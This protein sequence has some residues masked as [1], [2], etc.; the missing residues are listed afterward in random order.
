[1]AHFLERGCGVSI[2]NVINPEESN[3]MDWL[4]VDG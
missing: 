4:N 2:T 3:H 1:M